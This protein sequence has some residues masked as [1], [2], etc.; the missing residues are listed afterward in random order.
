MIS[1][2]NPEV[3]N[4]QTKKF[5]TMWSLED[6]NDLMYN[7]QSYGMHRAAEAFDVTTETVVRLAQKFG[8]K[9]KKDVMMKA[10]KE[11]KTNLR[12]RKEAEEKEQIEQDEKI[13][14]NL[15]LHYFFTLRMLE[16]NKDKSDEEIMR[17][18]KE[19]LNFRPN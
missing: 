8:I 5:K 9:I 12:E 6:L 15:V 1:L 10:K 18:A 3:Y 14:E 11:L 13:R 4:E 7:Y 16:K 2:I 19:M 17:L